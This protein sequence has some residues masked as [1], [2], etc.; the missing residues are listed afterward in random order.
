MHRS[1]GLV[2]S[3]STVAGGERSV[4]LFRIFLVL[5]MA[6]AIVGMASPGGAVVEQPGDDT[7]DE[8]ESANGGSS[9]AAGAGATFD[10]AASGDGLRL[11]VTSQE[12]P[13]SPTPIDKGGPTAQAVSELGAPNAFAAFPYP[14]ELILVA[15]G[16]IGGFTETDVP[17]YPLQARANQ[18]EPEQQVGG[19]PFVLRAEVTESGGARARAAFGGHRGLFGD[20]EGDG[21]DPPPS[22]GAFVS[23]AVVALTEDGAARAHAAARAI[24]LQVGPLEIGAMTA[25]ATALHGSDG[26]AETE[27][28]FALH[29]VSIDGQAVGLRDGELV[30]GDDDAGTP[31]GD[32]L[33][34]VDALLREFGIEYE[35]RPAQRTEE[36]EV[37][38]GLVLRFVNPQDLPSVPEGSHLTLRLGQVSAR[39]SEPETMD[40]GGL[41][42]N[43]GFGESPLDS[44]AGPVGANETPPDLQADPGPS[45]TEEPAPPSPQT[46]QGP[47]DQSET[48][49]APGGQSAQAAQF[50][51]ETLSGMSVYLIFVLAAAV[52]FGSTQVMRFVALSR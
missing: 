36:G 12:A 39:A 13:L 50:V 2:P 25:S 40:L 32:T 33:E 11:S 34:P 30:L 49:A 45:L 14:G 23:D 4:R 26:P 21:E 29:G 31:L 28:T 1:N 16:L 37:S 3:R 22:A 17:E 44:S 9:A 18:R 15:P 10:A 51:P 20:E 43:D 38:A 41:D 6:V 48:L 8:G 42:L 24:G 19:G 47:A 52:M 7:A 46:A 35:Y 27:S 5:A